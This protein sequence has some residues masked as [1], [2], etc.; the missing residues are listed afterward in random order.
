ME[1]QK[2]SPAA[3]AGLLPGDVIDSCQGKPL[4]G[5]SSRNQ[6]L[7]LSKWPESVPIELKIRRNREAKPLNI[8]PKDQKMTVTLVFDQRPE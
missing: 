2:E 4:Q 1:I 8:Q 5:E 6:L 3:K 7:L